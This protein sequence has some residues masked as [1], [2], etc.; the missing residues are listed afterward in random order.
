M[1]NTLLLAAV[2]ALGVSN[3]ALAANP[4]SDLPQGHWAY[5][6]VAKL[7]EAGVV[8][9]YPDGEFKGDN[10]MT[11][12]EMAQ[13]VAKALAKGAIGDNDRLVGEFADELNSL[14]VRV[15]RLEKKSDN[16]RITGEARVRYFHSKNKLLGELGD[17]SHEADLRTRIGLAGAINDKWSYNAMLQNTQDFGSDGGDEETKF[18]RGY[19]QGNI[20]SVE[21][22]AGR[23]DDLLVDGNILD[24][25]E[26]MDG[27][28]ISG[29]DKVKFSAFYGKAYEGIYDI[30]N[31]AK[32]F[33]AEV[34]SGE[35]PFNIHAGYYRT[36]GLRN[37]ALAVD[38]D[39]SSIWN[40]GVKF[41][42]GDL[43]IG[44]DY[45]RGDYEG[46][47][48]DSKNGYAVSLN[49]GE[50]NPEKVNSL[51][52]F[53]NYYS[54]PQS[55][56]WAH[57]TDAYTG[58]GAGFKGFGVGVGYTPMKNT[59]LTVAYYDTKDF[60]N[61]DKKDKRIWTDLTISF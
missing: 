7:A 36:N 15:A 21:V 3:S 30:E 22:K 55:T 19:L 53:A 58:D 61:S 49:I 34:S 35:E 40:L 51:G 8:D 11:R 26:G 2:I 25:D 13:I 29:G 56:F 50:A 52:F 54:Q 6:S 33:G 28:K 38:F 37:D 59:V 16:V 5:A 10:L 1:K 20:G 41:T 45:L 48:N 47:G 9:G 60:D 18:I 57:T 24:A 14:G 44:F 43:G 42:K 23:Y 32:I 46:N 27:I 17:S 31:G 39:D 12:Y 4:F